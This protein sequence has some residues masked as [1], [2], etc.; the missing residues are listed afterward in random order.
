MVVF[1]MRQL[2]LIC[3][4]IPLLCV[5]LVEAILIAFVL[6]IN[7]IRLS[8]ANFCLSLVKKESQEVTK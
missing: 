5:V 1:I 4:V 3:L 6:T 7:K 8:L 2:L